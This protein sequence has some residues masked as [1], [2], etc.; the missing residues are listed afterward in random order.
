MIMHSEKI[1]I[2]QFKVYDLQLYN[3]WSCHHS[4]TC[5]HD[6]QIIR[7]TSAHYIY[8]TLYSRYSDRKQ[9]TLSE[10]FLNTACKGYH[11]GMIH[12]QLQFYL[13]LIN[14]LSNSSSD[15]WAHSASVEYVCFSI[16]IILP[17]SKVQRTFWSM[18]VERKICQP[19]LSRTCSH[20]CE[21]SDSKLR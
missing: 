9:R 4:T 2:F 6:D 17:Y 7:Q 3:N 10:K 13:Y 8:S 16:L 21:K 19:W 1:W 20:M 18:T 12:Y 11:E 5:N 15:M 14:L